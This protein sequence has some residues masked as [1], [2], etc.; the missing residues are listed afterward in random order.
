[1][2]KNLL[3]LLIDS[4]IVVVEFTVAGIIFLKDYSVKV[5]Q[6]NV[7]RRWVLEFMDY[8]NTVFC[9][10]KNYLEKLETNI[11]YRILYE[12]VT[13]PMKDY[14]RELKKRRI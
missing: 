13:K 6:N 4:V 5:W 8:I 12:K 2:M 9:H 10:F 1:M 7:M 11:Q 14:Y 3:L